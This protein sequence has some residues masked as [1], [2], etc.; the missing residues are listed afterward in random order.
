MVTEVI[1]NGVS[2]PVISFNVESLEST[3]DKSLLK[4]TFDF[5]VKSGEE[6]HKITTLLYKMN[7]DVKVPKE[8]IEFKGTIHNYS[9]SFTNLYEKIMLG[10]FTLN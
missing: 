6:Y 4:I 1:L 5:K 2:I 8:E 10:C 7:F 9:T 3:T